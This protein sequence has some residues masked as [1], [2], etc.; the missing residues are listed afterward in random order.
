MADSLSFIDY[1]AQLG[2]ARSATLWRIWSGGGSKEG[3]LSRGFVKK[4]FGG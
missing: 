4:S 3:Y 1:V 2:F